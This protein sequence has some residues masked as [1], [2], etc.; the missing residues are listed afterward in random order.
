MKIGGDAVPLGVVGVSE[1]IVGEIEGTTSGVSVVGGDGVVGSGTDTAGLG[2]K[3]CGFKGL[4]SPPSLPAIASS[5]D[6]VA[7]GSGG[8]KSQGRGTSAAGIIHVAAH[9]T[10]CPWSCLLMALNSKSM[11]CEM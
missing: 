3:D 7:F 6:G 2:I 4:S 8:G 9:T 1:G 5:W 10:P 11:N